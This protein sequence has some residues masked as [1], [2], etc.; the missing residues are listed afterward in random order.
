MRSGNGP[1][2]YPMMNNMTINLDVFGVFMKIRIAAW[3]S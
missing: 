1:F 2:N 3:L